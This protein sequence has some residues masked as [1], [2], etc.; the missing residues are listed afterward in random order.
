[1]TLN[2]DKGTVTIDGGKA[3][4]AGRWLREQIGL[5]KVDRTQVARVHSGNALARRSK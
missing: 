2:V 1:V 4:E 3:T 5:V